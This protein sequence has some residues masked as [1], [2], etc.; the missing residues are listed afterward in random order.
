MKI[1]IAALLS[2]IGLL[3]A[4]VSA[5]Q[6]LTGAL[7]GTFTGATT[8]NSVS[9]SGNVEGQ[10]TALVSTNA[11]GATS[12]TASG[13]GTFGASGISGNWQITGYDTTTNRV[14]VVWSA[15]N[16]R[17]P[18]SS[19]GNGTADGSVSLALDPGT[20]RAT[21][22]FTGQV[23]SGGA[24]KTVNGTWVVQLQNPAPSSIHGS[25]DGSF[26]GSASY[27]GNVSGPVAGTW[28]ANI[29]A[30]GTVTGSA[31]G[32]FNGG[33]VAVPVYGSVCIC[34]SWTGTLVRNSQGIFSFQGSWT[35]PNVS[36][37]AAGTGG[38][39]M[40][41]TID[42]ST[43]PMTASGSFSGA[44]SFSFMTFTIP[45]SASGTWTATMPI[46]P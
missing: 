15:P 26:S 1:L 34:G 29:Q 46:A 16:N 4:P 20:G 2:F 38:G 30:D 19:S 42:A 22:A 36:G 35:Q 43:T 39:P 27:V 21:G 9:Y 24:A 14:S 12:I 3:S 28:V 45:I 6:T 18:L 10:W 7:A 25:V 44:T 17:G 11:S 41:W 23:F 40:V 33:F 13:S 37:S 31:N 5:S 8:D 32:T